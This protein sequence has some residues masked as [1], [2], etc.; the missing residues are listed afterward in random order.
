MKNKAKLWKD[1]SHALE[2][3]RLDQGI[4]IFI[5][6]KKYLYCF[7]FKNAIVHKYQLFNF[8]KYPIVALVVTLGTLPKKFTTYF[9]LF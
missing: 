4:K 5:S 7:L 9:V 8:Y 2:W 6:E 1:Q 3:P